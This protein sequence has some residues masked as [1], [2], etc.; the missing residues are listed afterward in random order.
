MALKPVNI[1]IA[2]FGEVGK[3]VADLVHERAERYRSIYGADVRVIAAC[4]SRAGILEPKGLGRSS[5]VAGRMAPGRTGPEFLSAADLHILVDATP[6]DFRTGGSGYQ[7]ARQALGL[8]RHVIAISKGALVF[9]YAGL[10]RLADDNRVKLKVSG[11]TAAALPTID[12]IQYNLRGCE[13]VTIDGILT[14]TS[15]FVLTRMMDGKTGLDEAVSDARAAGIAEKDPSFDIGGWDTACKIVILANAG[16]GASLS[17]SDVRVSGLEDISPAQIRAWKKDELVPK[18][19]GRL[20][21]ADGMIEAQVGLQLYPAQHLFAQITGK[22]KAV[23]VV[24]DSMGEMVVANSGAEPKA[25]AAA[26]LKDLEHILS[27]DR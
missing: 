19:V 11:A 6:T 20:S 16:L 24:T 10:R 15:N 27:D 23:R 21:K 5:S 4:G 22:A 12:L 9:D 2:G 17:M 13:I 8:G 1:A 3:A 25:T 26:A 18:L 14:A 7:Y